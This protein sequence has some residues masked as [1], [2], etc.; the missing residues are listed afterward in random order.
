M[1]RLSKLAN[2]RC[3][4]M[5]KSLFYEWQSEGKRDGDPQ[6]LGEEK[7]LTPRKEKFIKVG[8]ARRKFKVRSRTPVG[9]ELFLWSFKEGESEREW[10]E[11]TRRPWSIL[12]E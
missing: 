12:H 2:I 9:H 8:K 7:N 1:S 6:R 3:P 10:E 11:G 5:E 4:R